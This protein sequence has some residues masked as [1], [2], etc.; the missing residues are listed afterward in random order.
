MKRITNVDTWPD[1]WVEFTGAE[2]KKFYKEQDQYFI[3]SAIRNEYTKQFGV[4]MHPTSESVILS[5]RQAV[6]NRFKKNDPESCKNVMG[7]WLLMKYANANNCRQ[8]VIAL[9][10]DDFVFTIPMYPT[11]QV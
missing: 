10:P 5:I 3:C 4:E 9:V 7:A 1:T 8:R 6:P 11:R 2:L